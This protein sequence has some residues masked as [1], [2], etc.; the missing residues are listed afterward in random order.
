MH[1]AGD[2]RVWRY[3]DVKCRG[4]NKKA[5]HMHIDSLARPLSMA[6]LSIVRSFVNYVWTLR[7][8]F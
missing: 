2:Q 3:G 1:L 8:M 6:L 5:V 7:I 4:T